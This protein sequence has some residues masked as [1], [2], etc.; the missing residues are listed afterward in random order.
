M[1]T[2][3]RF[4]IAAT[5]TP[6]IGLTLR[7]AHA[8]TAPVFAKR[9]VAINGFDPVA[10]FTQS[11][12][13][14]GSADNTHDWMGA[15]WKFASVE[16]RDRFAADPEAFAP[17][18]GGYCAFAMSSGYIAKTDPDAWTVYDGKLY[19][20]YNLVVR[21]QWSQDIPGNIKRADGHW[22]GILDA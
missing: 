3:R 22:P 17:Q 9:G 19:L 15:L 2:R 7:P 6:L 10:Y 16:N 5:A 21:D 1:L 14:A 4:L 13:V 11:T 12:H 20:N 8:A 18:Y